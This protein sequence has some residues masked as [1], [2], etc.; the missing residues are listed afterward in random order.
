VRDLSFPGLCVSA[1]YP[2]KKAPSNKY[3]LRIRSNWQ[4]LEK[5]RNIDCRQASR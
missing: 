1:R 5:F 2:R 4:I 3:K